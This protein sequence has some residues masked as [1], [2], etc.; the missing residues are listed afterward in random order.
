M[1]QV[2]ISVGK[3]T[4]VLAQLDQSACANKILALNAK[5]EAVHV[6]EAG[7]GFEVVAQEISSQAVHSIALTVEVR[8]ILEELVATTR[9]SAAELRKQSI[10]D[11]ECLGSSRKEIQATLAHLEEANRSMLRSLQVAAEDGAELG[12][13]IDQALVTLQFQDRVSQRIQHVAESLLAL[14]EAAGQEHQPGVSVATQNVE[15]LDNLAKSYTMACERTAH[16]GANEPAETTES[17]DDV[18]LF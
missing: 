3:V 18:E 11:Q 2:E 15:L 7:K 17:G 10:A 9:S 6:G 8:T 5:I 16:T 1:E 4:K 13:E 14:N 12:K